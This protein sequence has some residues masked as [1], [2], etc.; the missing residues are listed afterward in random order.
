MTKV[1]CRSVGVFLLLAIF[2]P[3]WAQ[4]REAPKKQDQDPART[5]T[6]DPQR[7]NT[8]MQ[9]PVIGFFAAKLVLCNNSEI[10]MGTWA[11]GKASNQEVRQ[12]AEMMA[13]EHSQANQELSRFIADYSVRPMVSGQDSGV[14]SQPTGDRGS[15]DLARDKSGDQGSRTGQSPP[16]NPNSPSTTRTQEETSLRTDTGAGSLR[17][18]YDIC[19]TAH[20]FHKQHCK[21]MLGNL[22]GTE[23]DKAYMTSQV[24]AHVG[25]LSEL[26]A[27]EGR[28]SGDFQQ[29]VK[30][31]KGTVKGH[32]E[33]AKQL[34]KSLDN[35]ATSTQRSGTD[36]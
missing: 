36:R 3:L 34:C 1:W 28:S 7:G 25:V 22:S 16:P 33:K 19:R 11:A 32:L 10:E 26:E 24:A 17:E 35:A 29:F 14:T 4:Q 31:A 6:Q 12:F 20:D 9:Q 8:Q 5:T 30:Q 18:V 23:F 13:K 21:E 15:T 27:L 2:N